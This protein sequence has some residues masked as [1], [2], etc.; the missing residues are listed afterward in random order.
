MSQTYPPASAMEITQQVR[1]YAA[2][3][4]LDAEEAVKAGMEE[5]SDEFADAGGEIY[6]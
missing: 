3:Q 6:S 5:K 4:G 2:K 1:D